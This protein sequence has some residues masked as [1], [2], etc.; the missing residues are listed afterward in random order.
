MSARIAPLLLLAVALIAAAMPEQHAAYTER[1][2]AQAFDQNLRPVEGVEVY[3]DYR[4]NSVTTNARTKSK[5][6]DQNG[7]ANV[8]FTNYE[9]IENGTTSN[10]YTL[11]M[12]YGSQLFS[13]KLISNRDNKTRNVGQADLKSYY[14]QVRVHDQKG[15]ALRAALTI[16]KQ[17]K[18]ADATGSASFQMPPG[19]YTLKAEI[20]D[21]VKNRDV[22]VDQDRAVDVEVG[23]YPFEVYVNDDKHTPLVAKVQVGGKEGVT[24]EKGYANFTNITDESVQVI[25]QNNESVKKFTVNLE[26]QSRLDVVFDRTTPEIKE[27]HVTPLKTGAA[28]LRL[29]IEDP[30]QGASGIDT[31]IVT[32]EAEGVENQVP[33]Y[34]I[35]YNTYEVKIPIQPPKTFVKYVVKVSDREGNGAFA[36]GDYVVGGEGGNT[37]IPPVVPISPGQVQIGVFKGEMEMIVIGAVVAAVVLFGAFYY[38]KNRKKEEIGFAP[39]P[40][41]GT[42]PPQIPQA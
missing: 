7:I 1:I 10:T 24:N 6:T 41:A 18:V 11:Y 34:S 22:F 25:V 29:Y 23:L 12:K 13:Y 42:L 26:T 27:L 14:L 39:P 16:G 2:S 5:F 37:E 30:G 21:A 32:Y 33:A 35:G 20:A 9:E 40:P 28:T 15:R 3:I 4:L 38:L 31:V 17:T 36:S 19:N 8:T